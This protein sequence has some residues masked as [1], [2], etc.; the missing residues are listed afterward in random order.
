M[1]EV[2]GR[3]KYAQVVANGIAAEGVNDCDGL[4]LTLVTSG[5]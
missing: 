1:R 3:A 4:A 5:Q 2:E